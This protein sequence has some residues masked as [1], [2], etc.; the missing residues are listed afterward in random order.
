MPRALID[1]TVLYAGA[2]S[3]DAAHEAGLAILRGIDGSDLPE[4]VIL[5]HVLAETLNGLTTHA[6]HD[7]AVDFLDRIEENTRFHIES[8]TADERATA[9]AQFRQYEAFS[10]VDACLSA[11]LH[12]EALDYLYAFD[13]DFDAAAHISRLET[14]TNPYQPR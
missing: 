5:D 6:G 12:S 11:Y 13:D 4:V 7:A 3:R 10:F 8:L 2:Y 9:K 14:A 1:T